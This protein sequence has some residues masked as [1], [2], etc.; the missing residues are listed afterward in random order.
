MMNNKSRRDTEVMRV[1][2]V[3]GYLR[4]DRLQII[5]NSTLTDKTMLQIAFGD[6]TDSLPP[7]P[8]L[9]VTLLRP[10]NNYSDHGVLFKVVDGE[11][12]TTRYY[13]IRLAVSVTQYTLPCVDWNCVADDKPEQV[14]VNIQQYV[15]ARGIL[16]VLEVDMEDDGAV[17][18]EVPAQ[19]EAARKT[20][21]IIH[22]RAISVGDYAYSQTSPQVLLQTE[23]DTK[24]QEDFTAYLDVIAI[25]ANNKPPEYSLAQ[26]M[27]VLSIGALQGDMHDKEK[28]ENI[29]NAV[30]LYHT[31]DDEDSSDALTKAKALSLLPGWIQEI[32]DLI[33]NSGAGVSDYNR[34][35]FCE[36]L[37]DDVHAYDLSACFAQKE[38]DF[39]LPP[40]ILLNRGG[41][42]YTRT[43]TM[44]AALRVVV[45]H[46]PSNIIAF[47]QTETSWITRRWKLMTSNLYCYNFKQEQ[48]DVDDIR[49]R[50][51]NLYIDDWHRDE[52]DSLVVTAGIEAYYI[53]SAL[54]ILRTKQPAVKNLIRL[55][56]NG[57]VLT[58]EQLDVSYALL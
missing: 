10:D 45:A 21:E 44:L 30:R 13:S 46:L 9:V 7:A 19:V 5:L 50:Y 27:G 53:P 24:Q 37:D 11:D 40:F 4:A 51:L 42:I 52:D 31:I 58:K 6:A 43:T 54:Q 25:S 23:E 14:A 56:L 3:V 12:L 20:L 35:L 38:Q 39:D 1:I 22:D 55:L 2:L 41:R 47:V 15:P 29:S 32:N 57:G 17:K 48:K 34:Q 16:Q 49:E 18:E 26:A 28:K 33:L 36:C 8:Q